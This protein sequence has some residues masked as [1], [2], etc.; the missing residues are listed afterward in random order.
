MFRIGYLWNEAI[1]PFKISR[2]NILLD[3]FRRIDSMSKFLSCI[4]KNIRSLEIMRNLFSNKVER[5]IPQ[6][7]RDQLDNFWRQ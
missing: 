2:T 7:L 6:R 1:I 4:N 5:E 3:S